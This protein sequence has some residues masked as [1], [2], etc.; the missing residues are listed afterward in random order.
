MSVRGIR[1]C[2]HTSMRLQGKF[3]CCC[4]SLHWLILYLGENR[5]HEK[6]AVIG[7]LLTIKMSLYMRRLILL[8]VTK[9]DAHVLPDGLVTVPVQRG[10][11]QRH[12]YVYSKKKTMR[13]RSKIFLVGGGTIL[14][15]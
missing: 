1:P 8:I 11:V 6:E 12:T 9:V 10:R 13:E 5:C 3:Q 14:L 4:I 15:Q 2:K 7:N